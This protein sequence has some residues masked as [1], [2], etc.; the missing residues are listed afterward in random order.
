MSKDYTYAVARIRARETALLTSSDLD[1]LLNC[2]NYDDCISVLADRGWDCENISSYEQLLS[3]ENKKT[4]EL[5]NELTDDAEAFDVFLVPMD[6]HNLKAA[7]KSIITDSN[8]DNIFYQN[9]TVSAQSIYDAVKKRDYSALPDHIQNVAKDAV[10]ALLQTSDGQL[11]DIIIDKA[12]LE[13]LSEL[14]KISDNE[15]V[16]LYAEATVASANIKMAVRC[17]KTGK[18]IDFIKQCLASCETLNV[19]ALAAAAAKGRDEIYNY[20]A[21]TEYKGAVD[22]LKKSVSSFEIWCDNMIIS[23][24]KSQKWEPFT[25]GPLI[26]YILARDFEIKAVRIILSG[27]I[28][29]LDMSTVK[30][31]LRDMYV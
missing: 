4:W 13:S 29:N 5:I 12:S 20:L 11:C 8:V 21:Y 27:K 24:M 31:R 9:G 6:F 16:K 1:A 7:V 17:E 26:A 2:R 15:I 14:G 25:V 30:E 3:R 18:S 19:D 23:K 22:A 10:T 28:N